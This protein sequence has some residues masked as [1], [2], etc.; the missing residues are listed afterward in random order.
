MAWSCFQTRKY[1]D[2]KTLAFCFSYPWF[3]LVIALS[4]LCTLTFQCPAGCSLVNCNSGIL[5]DDFDPKIEH[6]KHVH[7]NMTMSCTC[8]DG[9]CENRIPTR[10]STIQL[11]FGVLFGVVCIVGFVVN[12]CVLDF[13]FFAFDDGFVNRKSLFTSTW[14]P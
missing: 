5:T 1:D 4:L 12:T 14:F 2:P 3:C 13:G 9:S 8:S 11:A 7:H 10:S 6:G